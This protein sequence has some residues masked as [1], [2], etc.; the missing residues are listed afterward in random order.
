MRMLSKNKEQ[1]PKDF[2]EVL[3]K[4]KTIKV[5]SSQTTQPSAS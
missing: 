5:F 1:R 2:H 3:M 4:L